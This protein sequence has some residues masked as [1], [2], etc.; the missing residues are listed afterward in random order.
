MNKCQLMKAT[1]LI[2]LS[3]MFAGQALAQDNQ[4]AANTDVQDAVIVWGTAVSS[5][6]LFLGEQ[7]LAVKQADHLSD[8]LRTL[9]GVDIGGTHSLNSRINVRGMDDR[10]LDVYMDGALQTNYIYHHIGNI[11]VNPDI[12]KSV[13]VQPGATSVT[14]GGIGGVIRFE[15]KDAKDLLAT[16]EN[17]FGGRL[18]A[19]YNSNAQ[20]SFSGA[21]YGQIAEKVDGLIYFN[22]VDRDN[23][24]DGDGLETIGSDGTTKN[25]LAKLGFDITE[26]QR[27]ELS[28]DVFEDAG[29]YTQRPDMGVLTNAAITGDILLPTEYSRNTLNL[30]YDLDLGE[31][32]RLDA[33]YS[34]NDLEFWRDETNPNL[35]A[36]TP[37]AVKEA[38]ADNQ[39][40]NITAYTDLKSGKVKH[41]L[42]YGLQY[43]DQN[44][45]YD[46]N[47]DVSDVAAESENEAQTIALFLENEISFA[48]RFFLRPGVRYTDYQVDY[49]DQNSSSSYDDVTFGLG[50]EAR[51]TDNLVLEGSYLELFKGPEL[52]EIFGGSGE[53]KVANINLTP[54]SGENVELGVKYT[55]GFGLA[56]LAFGLRAFKTTIDDYIDD[57]GTIDANIGTYELEGYEASAR[58][59]I[60]DFSL[61]TTIADS[62][63]DRSGLTQAPSSES[64]RETGQSIGIEAD[65]FITSLNLSL[66]WNSQITTDVT[67]ASGEDKEGYS[68]HN[69]SARWDDAIGVSGLSVTAGIDN[70]FDEAYTSQASRTGA[71]FH[72]VFGALVLNDVEPGRNVK[73]TLAK[74]F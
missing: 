12:L 23:F 67:T 30:S 19:G 21:G 60:D 26:N 16:T 68:L 4:D 15:T 38:A 43:F 63:H 46:G 69:I 2:G 57:Q 65:Y 27:I 62:D 24:E 40:V 41:A 48:D 44:L 14:H 37:P 20:T 73:L 32:F 31:L 64:L 3:V 34:M 61:T 55:T 22:Q 18:M 66:N 36:R 42:T 70:L 49:I 25:Y 10:N 53:N 72:P 54:Q 71:T 47:L 9:P 5:D 51:V 17:Q 8:L 56:D 59:T 6:S 45:T 13:E 74:T 52:P 28:Y 33:V 39:G 7:E 35:V 58:I 11:L 1:A 50:L 29:D